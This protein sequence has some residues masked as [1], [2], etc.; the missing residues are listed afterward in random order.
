M[1]GGHA[2]GLEAGHAVGRHQAAADDLLG[3]RPPRCR[4]ARRSDHRERR[5]ASRT[6]QALADADGLASGRPRCS[7]RRTVGMIGRDQVAGR[8]RSVAP[9]ARRRRAVSRRGPSA[10]L[11]GLVQHAGLAEPFSIERPGSRRAKIRRRR[12]A[13]PDAGAHLGLQTALWVRFTVEAG[14]GMQPRPVRRGA[15]RRSRLSV[16]PRTAG[17]AGAARSASA[18]RL[19][20]GT[21]CPTWSARWARSAHRGML[22]LSLSSMRG[23]VGA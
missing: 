7:A 19:V 12:P 2:A 16:A 6:G 15:S 9:A 3:V 1:A 14:P 13:R 8:R 18:R 10:F 21:G 23:A 20:S 4:T 17:E 5:P 11:A 22:V